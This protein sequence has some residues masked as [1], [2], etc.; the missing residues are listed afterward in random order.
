[1]QAILQSSEFLEAQA[2]HDAAVSAAE[3]SNVTA[4]E[5]LAVAFFEGKPTG[6]APS[7]ATARTE[8]ENAVYALT[9]AKNA[10]VILDSKLADCPGGGWVC[11]RPR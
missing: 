11:Q 8:L 2:R 10:R 1:M 9:V 3:E 6:S 4:A 7:A 5:D